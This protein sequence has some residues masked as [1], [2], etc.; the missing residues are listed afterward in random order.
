MKALTH[1]DDLEAQHHELG[2]MSARWRTVDGVKLGMSRID[3]LPGAQSTPAHEHTAEEELFYVLRGDGVWWQDGAT[4]AIGEGDVI[5]AEPRGGAHTVIGGEDGVDVL[6]FGPR[7]DIEV[8]HLPRPGVL[9]VGGVATLRA[10]TKHQ[11]L[12]EVEAGPVERVEPGPRPA[13]VV[14]MT[15]VPASEEDRPGWEQVER[16]IG[17]H[18]G[19]RTTGM[20]LMEIAPAARSCPFHCHSAEEELFVVLW[21]EGTLRLGDD[22]HTLRAGHVVSR[23]AGTRIAHQFIAGDG[24][25]GVLAYSDID[26]NDLAFYPD[27]NKVKL[28]GLN[29]MMRVEP[30]DYWDGED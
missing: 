21:G 27:S 14:H 9:R 16:R 5:F 8:T 26:P 4:T 3:V 7:H 30:L 15:D 20:T 10:E 18:L 12:F 25:L 6:A 11:W 28:R 22:R 17:R 2:P 1:W 29:V 19:A 24:G 23:P 13:N